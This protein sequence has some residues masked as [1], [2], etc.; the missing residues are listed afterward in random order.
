MLL[1]LTIYKLIKL[2]IMKNNFNTITQEDE[3]A[4]DRYRGL[5]RLI[6]LVAL[7]LALQLSFNPI[8]EARPANLQCPGGGNIAGNIDS[9]SDKGQPT[10]FSTVKHNFIGGLPRGTRIG[11]TISDSRP[12][13]IAPVDARVVIP[14]P[15]PDLNGCTINELRS[16]IPRG[17]E[18]FIRL[19]NGQRV[20]LDNTIIVRNNGEISDFK[21]LLA[22]DGDIQGFSGAVLFLFINDKYVQVGNFIGST[23]DFIV[24]GTPDG[25][26][27]LIGSNGAVL[28]IT[29]RN[30]EMN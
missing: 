9:Y 1:S 15:N 11:G 21:G 25:K 5:R 3:Q 14:I 23:R 29:G 10:T 13:A 20:N 17:V 28:D 8:A 6:A 4:S 26:V 24:L 27:L 12:R 22:K 7:P 2:F 16:P 19:T 18:Q 30:V